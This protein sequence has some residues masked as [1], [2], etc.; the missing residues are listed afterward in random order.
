MSTTEV[1]YLYFG[2]KMWPRMIISLWSLRKHWNGKVCV[3]CR[4]RDDYDRLVPACAKFD[5]CA[6]VMPPSQRGTTPHNKMAITEWIKSEYAICMDADTLIEGDLSPLVGHE[7]AVTHHGA[8][9]GLSIQSVRRANFYR[10][11]DRSLDPVIEKYG[12]T[13]SPDINAGVFSCRNG[14]RQIEIIQALLHRVVSA[15]RKAPPSRYTNKLTLRSGRL[16]SPTDFAF[17]L[18]CGWVEH[19]LLSDKYNCCSRHG[20]DWDKAVV[21]HFVARSHGRGF[22]EYRLALQTVLDNNVAGFADH[23]GRMDLE[24]RNLLTRMEKGY[25]DA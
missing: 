9:T 23:K 3:Y 24:M 5:I 2:R 19:T 15:G 4:S 16:P 14:C 18:A 13:E 17:S 12:T 25:Y 11:M 21:K 10:G 6:T 7:F 1:A 22:P 20:T 8:R